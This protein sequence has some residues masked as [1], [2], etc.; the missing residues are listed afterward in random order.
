MLCFQMY[1]RDLNVWKES[2]ELV[3]MTYSF[4][5][6]FP[7]NE[8]YALSSQIRRSVVSIPSN[9]AEGCGRGTNKELLYFL[10]V[11]SGSLCELETQMYLADELG[12]IED[13]EMFDE[14][15]EK[16][17]KLLTGFK[18]HIKEQITKTEL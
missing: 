16:V 8:E 11:A 9:I 3:K 14:Q 5:D 2:V 1:H 10:N 17:Q 13:K 15:F 7:K 4:I 6:A 12:Y 18:K